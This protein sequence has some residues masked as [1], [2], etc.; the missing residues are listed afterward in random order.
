MVAWFITYVYYTVL[1]N[2]NAFKNS[3]LE[4][5]KITSLPLLRNFDVPK[6]YRQAL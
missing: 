3:N 6:S 1:N 5:T 2:I 4:Y